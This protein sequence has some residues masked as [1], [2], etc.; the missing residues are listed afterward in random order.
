MDFSSLLPPWQLGVQENSKNS[1]ASAASL[2]RPGLPW[3]QDCSTA[4]PSSAAAAP[5]ANLSRSQGGPFY[6]HFICHY[7]L[8]TF[9][10]Q[11]QLDDGSLITPFAH[12]AG[13]YCF[14]HFVSRELASEWPRPR[15]Q[16]KI[17]G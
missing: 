12:P 9:W 17:S 8:Q 4:F 5:G 1:S 11:I 10:G 15:L 13:K 14:L 3:F 16:V 6:K 7:V 2:L